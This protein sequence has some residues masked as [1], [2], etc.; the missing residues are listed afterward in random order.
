M[1]GETEATVWSIDMVQEAFVA[2]H[3]LWW[4]TPG[5]GRWPFA[6]DGPWSQIVAEAGDVIGEAS[7]D[8]LDTGTQLIDVITVDTNVRP[9]TA[10]DMAEVGERDRVTAWL[11]LLPDPVDRMIVHRAT[12]AMWQGE[13]RPPWKQIKRALRWPKGLDALA[14]HYRKSLASIA[15]RLNGWPSRKARTMATAW[16]A[17]E[18]WQGPPDSP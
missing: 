5:D 11:Q 18:P 15:C 4:R 16:R 10:L 8:V 7:T 12:L 14:F 3:D 6:G 13:S 1:A 2:C 9:R 17:N